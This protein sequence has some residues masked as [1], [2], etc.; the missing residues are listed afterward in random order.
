MDSFSLP[1]I[2]APDI[3]KNIGTE[4][5]QNIDTNNYTQYCISVLL[6]AEKRKNPF[7]PV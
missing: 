7:A 6:Y 2:R 3:A 4:N 1:N 5:L